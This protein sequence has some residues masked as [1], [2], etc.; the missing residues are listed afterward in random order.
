[1]RSHIRDTTRDTAK[2]ATR[3]ATRIAL[4]TAILLA[5]ATFTFG[6]DVFVSDAEAQVR[7]LRKTGKFEAASEIVKDD[8]DAFSYKPA[9]VTR[10]QTLEPTDVYRV[11]WENGDTLYESGIDLLESGE[12]DNAINSLKAALDG[13]SDEIFKHYIREKILSAHV[14]AGA[15]S[16]GSQH[17]SKAITLAESFLSDHPK[18]RLTASVRLLLG[19]AQMQSGDHGAAEQTLKSLENEARG[20]F[21]EDWEVRA[22]RWGARNLELK[23]SYAEAKNLYASLASTAKRAADTAAD[24]TLLR[25]EMRSLEQYGLVQQGTCLLANGELDEAERY[26]SQMLRDAERNDQK[27]LIGGAHN[28]LGRVAFERGEYKSARFQFLL[29]SV[30]YFHD[31]AEAIKALYWIGECYEKLEGDEPGA[32]ARAAEYYREVVER[33]KSSRLNSPWAAKA[34]TKI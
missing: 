27:D 32:R 3:L 5:A 1:M 29:V 9:G 31:P 18:A 23:G 8:I 16:S 34:K 7:I 19:R 26:Y 4:R 2:V 17:N 14:A 20:S 30:K 11:V 22:K 24:G 10:A 12:Y 15:A 13:A 25:K 6:I 21:G 33:N 28:G